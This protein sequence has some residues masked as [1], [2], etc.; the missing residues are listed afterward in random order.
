[1]NTDESLH[2][3]IGLSTERYAFF[4]DRATFASPGAPLRGAAIKRL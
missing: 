4:I 2:V 1:M 3:K